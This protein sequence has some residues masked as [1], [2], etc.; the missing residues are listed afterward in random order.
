M[1]MEDLKRKTDELTS[2]ANANDRMNN[3]I[4][5]L[6]IIGA[7]LNFIINGMKLG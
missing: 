7:L 3:A 6:T 1:R 2:K 5:V 4:V